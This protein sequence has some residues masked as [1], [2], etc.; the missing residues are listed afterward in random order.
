MFIANH[1]LFAVVVTSW[2]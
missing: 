2:L 1:N